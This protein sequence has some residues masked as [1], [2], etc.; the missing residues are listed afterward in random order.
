M[1]LVKT[2]NFSER[3]EPVSVSYKLGGRNEKDTNTI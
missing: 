1:G 2:R 3:N